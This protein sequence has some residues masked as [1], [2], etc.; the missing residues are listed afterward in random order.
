MKN[1]TRIIA[2]AIIAFSTVTA[3]AQKKEK[4]ISGTIIYSIES[5]GETPVPLNITE[6][7]MK[8]LDDKAISPQGNVIVVGRTV[9][10]IMDLSQVQMIVQQTGADFDYAGPWKAYLKEEVTQ[11]GI[12]SLFLDGGYKIEYLN[13]TKEI[14]G[15]TAKKAK[16]LIKSENESV[17]ELEVW[18]TEEIGPEYDFI[19]IR[20]LKGFPLEYTTPYG[21]NSA[22]K[23]TVKEI[24]K[25]KIKDAEFLL[26]AGYE[27]IT[28]ENFLD[29]QEKLQILM[30]EMQY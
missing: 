3:F 13:D 9:Y 26:P 21:E 23:F 15:I 5:V 27:Q 6:Q 28:T 1:L 25:K 16:V 4:K 14:L 12:D 19:T 10:T 17:T 11:S 18:Y 2:F 8:V 20:G 7:S 29:L 22:I 30:E 24:G